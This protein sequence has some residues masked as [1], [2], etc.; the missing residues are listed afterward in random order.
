M[1]DT[2][3]SC[4]NIYGSLCQLQEEC[5]SGGA[6]TEDAEALVAAARNDLSQLE[7]TL[8]SIAGQAVELA[9]SQKHALKVSRLLLTRQCCR[10]QLLVGS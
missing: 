6:V 2:Q 4:R 1:S 5:D 9:E 3:P 8:K 10:K 7:Q